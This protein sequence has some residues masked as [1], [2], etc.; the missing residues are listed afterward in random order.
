MSTYVISDIHGQLNAF[1]GMLSMISFNY[2]SDKLYL[3]GDYVDWGPESIK[4]LQ[5]IM[6]LTSKYGN[7]KALIGNHDLM[8]YNVISNIPNN[9]SFEQAY[10]VGY[11]VDYGCWFENSGDITLAKYIR[12]SDEEK[13][14]IKKFLTTLPYYAVT[15]EI[16]GEIY[17]LCHSKP[18]VRG[19]RLEDV[20]WDRIVDSRLPRS[21]IDRTDKAIL[22]SGHTITVNYNSYDDNGM[23]KIYKSPNNRYINIDCGAKLLGNKRICR[24]AAIRLEDLEEFYIDSEMISLCD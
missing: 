10:D 18:F 17:Y 11:K 13:S 23:L 3:L 21:F 4:T 16:N 6:E 1:K 5:Y 9:Y 14:S 12:L 20:V 24:L 15:D 7:I 2:T 19:M 22:V 8:M